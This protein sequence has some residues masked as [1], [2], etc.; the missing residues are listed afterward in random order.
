MNQFAGGHVFARRQIVSAALVLVLA[1]VAGLLGAL[2]YLRSEALREGEQTTRLIAQLVAE[3]TTRSLQTVGQA[4]ELA[5]TQLAELDSRGRLNESEARVVLLRSLD[6]LPYVRAMWVLDERGILQLDSDLGNVGVDLADRDYFKV[7]QERPGTGFYIGTPV[8][9]RSIGTWL[10]SAVLPIRDEKQRFKGVIVAAVQPDYFDHIWDAAGVGRGGSIALL[11]RDGVLM[12]RSPYVESAMG[13][14]NAASAAFV[15]RLRASSAGQSS[16]ESAIDRQ[17]QITAYQQLTD[18]PDLVVVVGKSYEVLLA[19]WRRTAVLA[20]VGWCIAVAVLAYLC[21]LLVGEL[22][23]RQRSEERSNQS[24]RI[25]AIGTLAGGIAHDFNNILGGILGNLTLARSLL[26]PGHA[27]LG[28]LQ[29]IQKGGMRA[30]ALVHQIL[31]F[32]RDQPHEMNVVALQPLVDETL[33]L[34]RA[35]LPAGIDMTRRLTDEPVFVSGDATRLQQVLMNLCTNAWHALA[36]GLGRIEVG[37]ERVD[38][39]GSSAELAGVTGAGP[40]AHFWVSDT[41]R[42]IDAAVRKR[43]FEPFFTT[44]TKEGGTGLGLSVVQGIVTAHHGAISVESELGAGSTFHVHLPLVAEGVDVPAL[45]ALAE[46]PPDGH[47]KRVLCV[48][49]DEV[50]LLMVERLLKM[51]NFEVTAFSRPADAVAALEDDAAR[52]DAVVT[53]QDMPEM[54]GVELACAVH[55]IAPRLPVLLSTGYVSAE[56]TA[57]AQAAGVRELLRKEASYQEL[58]GALERVLANDELE[59]AEPMAR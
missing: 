49:D 18:H 20:V 5:R 56:L 54:S 31:A 32:S 11:N 1:S 35:S 14:S 47:G 46:A 3:Q 50:I 22:E 55:R 52:Y 12:M 33:G 27:A 19:P 25:E 34:L 6:S 15:A 4:L 23:R 43:M 42:G 28:Y 38:L 30:R 58:P 57:H 29:E 16:G 13:R 39:D 26:V 37:L 9:S 53:D 45:P 8:R 40:Y 44:R 41:G 7:Y 51:H 21:S 24:Q 10:V 2:A 17:Y 36:S 59:S 48:D